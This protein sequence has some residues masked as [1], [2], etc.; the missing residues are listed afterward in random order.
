M[1][2]A[3]RVQESTRADGLTRLER[4]AVETLAYADVFDYPLTLR[5]LHRY[6]RMP[7]AS[8]AQL[9][10]EVLPALVTKGLIVE[11]GDLLMLPDRESIA[12]LRESRHHS[13]A[14]LWPRARRYAAM[15]ARFP[16]V[17]LVAVSG[18]LAVDNVHPRDD[19]DY[20]VVTAPGRLWT[21]RA[22]VVALVRLAA[23]FGDTL[24]PNYFVTTGA[25][26]LAERSVFVAHELT[27][28]VP[29]SGWSVYRQL[30][31]ANAWTSR[32]LPNAQGP[33]RLDASRSDAETRPGRVL[34][35]LGTTRAGEQLE[36]WEMLRKLEKLRRRG[37]SS[38]EVTLSADCCKGH[39]DG[40]GRRIMAAYNQR[41]LDLGLEGAR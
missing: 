33:P 41:L 22:L 35:R 34:E 25:M 32:F 27:Q 17:R 21:A 29:L 39:F 10:L 36:R 4:S 12:D 24:C 28:L 7:C 18:S 8:P 37:L 6:L 31:S 30:R 38:G 11:H 13:S 20:F 40:H 5:E 23:R 2:H 1:L 26:S 19:I 3:L 16:F 14:R 15:M 9:R